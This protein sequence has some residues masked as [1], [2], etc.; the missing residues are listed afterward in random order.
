MTP[1][2]FKKAMIEIVGRTPE[3]KGYGDPEGSHSAADDLL[4]QVLKDLG[5][6]EGIEIFLESERWYA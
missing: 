5:Y 4:C 2:E 1:E 3:K 6:N